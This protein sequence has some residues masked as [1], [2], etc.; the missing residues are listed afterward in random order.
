[1]STRFPFLK[2]RSVVL[3]IVKSSQSSLNGLL[4]S[5]RSR[6]YLLL[7]VMIAIGL[8][9]QERGKS[10]FNIDSFVAYPFCPG[11]LELLL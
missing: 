6:L 3:V 9:W 10:W 1:M 11:T 2:N 5:Y 7:K 8:S 4:S